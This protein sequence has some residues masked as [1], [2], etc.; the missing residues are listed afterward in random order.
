[1]VHSCVQSKAARNATIL[2]PNSSARRED[3]RAPRISHAHRD[4]LACSSRQWV[5]SLHRKAGV[6]GLGDQL[7]R[8][9]AGLDTQRHSSARSG[10]AD[11]HGRWTD[12][13]RARTSHE[14]DALGCLGGNRRGVGAVRRHGG[15][16]GGTW[17]RQGPPR[18]GLRERSEQERMPRTALLAPQE[19]RSWVLASMHRYRMHPQSRRRRAARAPRA[20]MR[21]TRLSL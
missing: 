4:V 7:P 17:D 18:R 2:T 20:V 11:V 15:H 9:L 6:V 3:C 19:T 21:L 5:Q 12:G 13:S 14:G 1:M 8:A 16:G 10:R